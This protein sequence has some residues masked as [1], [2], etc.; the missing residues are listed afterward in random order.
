MS[1][2]RVKTIHRKI[3]D[4]PDL[5]GRAYYQ[6]LG[7]KIGEISPMFKILAIR[8]TENQ[9]FRNWLRT[10][11]IEIVRKNMLY[12]LSFGSEE[13]ELMFVLTYM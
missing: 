12:Y 7:K 1:D 10:M 6:Y 4:D 5:L 2:T 9:D 11:N 8:A 13:G 3:V